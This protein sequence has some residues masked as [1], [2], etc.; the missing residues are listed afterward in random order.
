MNAEQIR[1]RHHAE[2][3]NAEWQAILA[4]MSDAEL[5]LT[6]SLCVHHK[7]IALLAIPAHVFTLCLSLAVTNE[8]ERR[9][10]AAVGR[11]EEESE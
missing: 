1:I 4:S 3:A 2:Q 8:L 7:A 11:D 6:G 10:D 9:V 5:Q